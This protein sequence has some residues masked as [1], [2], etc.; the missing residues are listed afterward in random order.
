MEN[1]SLPQYL[2]AFMVDAM[3][4]AGIPLAIAT[5]IGLVISIFQAIT[6]IQD[7]TLGQ[8]AKLVTISAALLLGGAQLV[9]PFLNNSQRVFDSISTVGR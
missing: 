4:I 8:T 7:Q 3:M 2:V 9:S 6:Q 5:V 1:A